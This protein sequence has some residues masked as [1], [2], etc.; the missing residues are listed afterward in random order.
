MMSRDT[1][2]VGSIRWLARRCA[3]C[4]QRVAQ[5]EELRRSARLVAI[6]SV[7]N[8]GV[9]ETWVR[10]SYCHGAEAGH[11]WESDALAHRPGRIQ[12]LQSTPSSPRHKFWRQRR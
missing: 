2:R 8:A 5:H 1:W 12:V 6:P 3:N 10:E 11:V 7:P 9:A 4:G